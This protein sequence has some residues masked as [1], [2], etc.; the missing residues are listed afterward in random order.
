MQE[1]HT[2]KRRRD[3]TSEEHDQR[4]PPRYLSDYSHS[5]TKEESGSLLL[6]DPMMGT[7]PKV[8]TPK[9]WIAAQRLSGGGPCDDSQRGLLRPACANR[10]VRIGAVLSTA[11]VMWD[12]QQCPRHDAWTFIPNWPGDVGSV[13]FAVNSPLR[14]VSASGTLTLHPLFEW[15]PSSSPHFS[16]YPQVLTLL[17]GRGELEKA[18]T[19]SLA[20][21]LPGDSRRVHLTVNSPS[22]IVTTSGILTLHPL[23]RLAGRPLNAGLSAGL[24]R[25][26][27]V[28]KPKPPPS[29]K[30]KK[31]TSK[32][33]DKGQGNALRGRKAKRPLYICTLIF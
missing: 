29:T 5:R 27:L 12:G 10:R 8:D 31:K 15:T 26:P 25:G 33:K 24:C 4:A 9:V 14:T 32:A 3:E 20:R 1:A 18:F 23:T 2:L 28:H 16:H 17:S 6:D 30:D 21:I 11:P 13:H 19:W 22:K 7:N